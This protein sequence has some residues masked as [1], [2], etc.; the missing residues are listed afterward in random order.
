MQ[1]NLGPCDLGHAL[2]TCTLA[3]AEIIN[4]H[5]IV[6]GFQELNTRVASN[7]PR[8]TCD[9]D[10]HRPIFHFTVVE[11]FTFLRPNTEKPF[12][13]SHI[14]A[15]DSQYRPRDEPVQAD[16]TGSRLVA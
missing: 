15:Q 11:T 16:A 13:I 2:D 12:G 10:F 8:S 14:P 6:T 3:V 1:L 4:N 9:Q 5:H 7:V